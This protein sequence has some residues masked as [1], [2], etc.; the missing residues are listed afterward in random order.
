MVCPQ[1]VQWG[2]DDPR[3]PLRDVWWGCSP[4]SDSE[5]VITHFLGVSFIPSV[6]PTVFLKRLSY[7]SAKLCRN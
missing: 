2:A 4:D 6:L 7:P 5:S 1:D 3:C